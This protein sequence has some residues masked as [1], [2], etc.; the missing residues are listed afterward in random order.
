MGDMKIPVALTVNEKVAADSPLKQRIF[1]W[2]L[3][4]GR[5]VFQARIEHRT[6]GAL[7]RAQHALADRLVFAKLRKRGAKV[8]ATV[9]PPAGNTSPTLVA[10]LK[11]KLEKKKKK[12]R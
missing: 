12:K 1:R 3:G 8:R 4:V 5:R 10:T 11:V 9:T 2:A 7:L 6:P